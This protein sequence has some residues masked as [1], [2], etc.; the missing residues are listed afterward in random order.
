MD[1]SALQCYT[2]LYKAVTRKGFSNRGVNC[3]AVLRL[4]KHKLS[5]QAET[6]LSLIPTWS[7]AERETCSL[8]NVDD[9]TEWGWGIL[10]S[11][12][13]ITSCKVMS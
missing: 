8:S 4:F 1:L 13:G 3:A 10:S 5:S 12:G 11:R 7:Y 9:H 6:F 2:L